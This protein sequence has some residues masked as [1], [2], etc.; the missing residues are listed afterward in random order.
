MNPFYNIGISSYRLAARIVSPWNPK[1]KKMVQGQDSTMDY[2]TQTLD[3]KGGYI[4]IHTASLGEFEQG[5]PLIEKIKQEHHDAKI[6][7]SFFSPSGYEVR[8]DYDK[9]DAVCYLPMDTPKR[10][11]AFLDVVKPK[12]AIFVKYEFW[13]NYLSELKSRDVPTYIISSIFR[14]K[15]PLLSSFPLEFAY[16]SQPFDTCIWF[17]KSPQIFYH[18][19]WIRIDQ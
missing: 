10:V 11:K 17:C 3:P 8:K 13:G 4:W 2:L 5:R 7:L 16:I 18:R 6:L 9:V 14:P 15:L 12:M 1:A 19:R